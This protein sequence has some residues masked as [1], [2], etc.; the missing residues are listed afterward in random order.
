MLEDVMA[1]L[2]K[3]S[4]QEKKLI[5]IFDEFQEVLKIG[6]GLDKQLRSII[7]LQSGLN[8]I[9]MGSQEGMMLEIFERKKSIRTIP[10]NWL[11][12]CLIRLR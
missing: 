2:Q 10:S 11:S 12:K 4:T 1:L 8:Y 5:I 3:L 6:K 7:Q 9:F